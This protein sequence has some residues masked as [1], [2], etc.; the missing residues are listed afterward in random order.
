MF[1]PRI[2]KEWYKSMGPV[3]ITHY[4]EPTTQS[5]SKCLIAVRGLVEWLKKKM[6]LL[7]KSEVL[8]SSP[9]AEKKKAVRL[10]AHKSFLAYSGYCKN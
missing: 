2:F 5:H 4:M 10:L 8:S 1:P 6:H 9:S 7:S 3:K